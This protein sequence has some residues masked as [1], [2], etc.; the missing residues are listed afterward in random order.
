LSGRDQLDLFIHTPES[1][2]AIE[3]LERMERAD[4][5]R[6]HNAAS[7]GSVGSF[8]ACQYLSIVYRR[9]AGALE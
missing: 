9:P 3:E 1:V 7:W 5:L 6:A 8:L 4:R 2:A